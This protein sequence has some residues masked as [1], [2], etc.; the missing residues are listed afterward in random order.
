[1]SIPAQQ[2]VTFTVHLAGPIDIPLSIDLFKRSGDDLLDRW[3]GTTLI[4]TLPLNGQH[5]AYACTVQGTRQE[6]AL[7][8]SIEDACY[9]SAIQQAI[10][11]T[12]LPVP[13]SFNTLLQKDPIVAQLHQRFPGL[14][15]VRQFDLLAALIRSISAQQVN[16]RWA[17]TIRSRLAESFGEAHQVGGQIVYSFSPERLAAASVADIRALQWSTRKAEYVISAAEAVASGQ[18]R[19]AEL[20]ELPDDE[21]IERLTK[22]R[23]IGRW[24]AEWLLLR[25]LGRSCVVAGDLG[26]RKAISQAYLGQPLASEQEVREA[27]AHWGDCAAIA[28]GLLL[29]TLSDPIP[30]KKTAKAKAEKI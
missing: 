19:L 7:L 15:P 6:P 2:H 5:I 4:R 11:S 25:T 26:V 24:T 28:Q 9:Q 27:T 14:R 22:L 17:T 13:S 12:F 1:M 20:I 29:E 18:L 21:V 10:L 23:G 8:V 16:L 30:A 3:D